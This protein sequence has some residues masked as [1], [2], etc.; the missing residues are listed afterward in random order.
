MTLTPAG[1]GRREIGPSRRVLIR[2]FFKTYHE[3]ATIQFWPTKTERPMTVIIITLA[4]LVAAQWPDLLRE[5]RG[6]TRTRRRRY[7]RAYS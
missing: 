3:D 6:Y 5:A 4:A 2:F 1:Q 7:R